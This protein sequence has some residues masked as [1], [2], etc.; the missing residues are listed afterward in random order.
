MPIQNQRVPLV[1]IHD[2][3]QPGQMPRT[4]GSSPDFLAAGF[5]PSFSGFSPTFPLRFQ[6]RMAASSS[7]DIPVNSHN[8]YGCTDTT[9]IPS[10]NHGK[11]EGLTSL[12]QMARTKVEVKTTFCP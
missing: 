11:K 2:V 4:M 8:Y 5:Q 12:S 3:Q 10:R 6:Y 7:A 9:K 1:P